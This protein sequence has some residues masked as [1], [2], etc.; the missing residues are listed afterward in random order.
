ML[1]KKRRNKNKKGDTCQKK[2]NIL[3]QNTIK[4]GLR[5]TKNTKI[6]FIRNKATKDDLDELN[7]LIQK[8]LKNFE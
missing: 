8:K 2:K 7:E 5:R 6:I 3:K 4:N 1:I